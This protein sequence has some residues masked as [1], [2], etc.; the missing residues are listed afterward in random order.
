MVKTRFAIV[1][2]NTHCY[3]LFIVI[4]IGINNDKSNHSTRNQYYR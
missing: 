1:M 4:P 3:Y 2:I